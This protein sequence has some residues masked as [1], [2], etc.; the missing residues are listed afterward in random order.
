MQV[1][2]LE[3]YC[4]HNNVYWKETKYLYPFCKDVHHKS[5]DKKQEQNSVYYPFS[6]LD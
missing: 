4:L 3:V 6:N 2:A 1:A 5:V